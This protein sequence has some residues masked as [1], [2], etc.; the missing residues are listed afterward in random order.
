MNMSRLLRTLAVM[1]ATL[2]LGA[3]IG[4]PDRVRHVDLRQQVPLAG[5]PSTH[6]GKWPDAAWW[7]Q[8]HD[9]Q[10]DTLIG[11]ALKGDTSL[12]AARSRVELARASARLT[13]AQVGLRINGSAQVSRQRMSENGLIPTRF[14]GFT[15]YTQGDIGIQGSYDFD[16]WGGHR[17]AVEAAIGEMRAAQAGRSAAALELETGIARTYFG[18]L[19]DQARLQKARQ[20]VASQQHLVRILKARVDAGLDPSDNL[21]QARANYASARELEAALEGSARIRKAVLA[22]LIGVAPANLPPLKPRPL[23]VAE[24]TLP[25]DAGLDLIARRPDI[26][27]RRWQ[28]EAAMRGT[29]AARTRFFPDLSIS[30]LAGFSS[31][32]MGKLLNPGSRVLTITPAVHLP[33]FEGGQLRAGFGVSKARLD[34]AVA[35]YNNAVLDAARQVA[36]GVLDL[37]RLRAQRRQKDKQLQAVSALES[38]ASARNR[39]G[40]TNLIPVLEAR[41]RSLSQRDALLQ[42]DAQILDADV[43]LIQALGG[44]YRMR[45][46]VSNTPSASDPEPA[47]ASRQALSHE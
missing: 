32:D 25:A 12:A 17:D 24:T 39:R 2:L 22:A 37:D 38:N 27:A 23:P 9:P 6:G 31:I 5:L 34:Q 20:L 19:A 3:C 14:L 44:G 29:D 1:L 30:A 7:K 35:Q 40:I 13:A 36:T 18:W 15:W 21:E 11:H 46:P 28:V 10:L 42:L 16:L 4:V 45:A 41:A 33:I 43:G 8:Y 26:A 47:N